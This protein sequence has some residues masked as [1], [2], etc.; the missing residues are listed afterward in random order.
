[1]QKDKLNFKIM[2]NQDQACSFC[3]GLTKLFNKNSFESI[4]ALPEAVGKGYCKRIVIQPLCEMVIYDMTF[5][6]DISLFQSQNQSWYTL[7]FSLGE[8]T[9]G[10]VCLKERMLE[11]KGCG[12]VIGRRDNSTFNYQAHK[13]YYGMTIYMHSESLTCFIRND[14]IRHLFIKSLDS[15][16][17]LYKNKTPLC[18]TCI[19]HDILHC[20]YPNDLKI[21]YLEAKIMELLAVYM[22]FTSYENTKT[23]HSLKHS[24]EDIDSLYKAKKILDEDVVFP[25]TLNKLAK[26]VCLNEYKLK[27]GFKELFGMPVHAYVIDKRLEIARQLMASKRLRVTE[28]ALLVGYSDS[29]HFASKFRKKYGMNPSE[30]LKCH[31]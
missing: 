16:P 25:P 22:E 1:M 19:L 18:M 23:S 15:L 2:N 11:N 7:D 12:I 20:R 21:M 31:I 29:S 4:W 24:K 30:Y 17:Y 26:L 3:I 8:D 6:E 28:V 14:S 27:N 9:R 10:H 13:R 5:Y